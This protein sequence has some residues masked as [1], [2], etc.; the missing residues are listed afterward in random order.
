MRIK[1]IQIT[2]YLFV[3]LQLNGCG[4]LPKQ[5]GKWIHP[6]NS[7]AIIKKDHYECV[8]QAWKLHPEELGYISANN[9]YWEE[10][11]NARTECRYNE[12]SNITNCHHYPAKDKTWVESD[13][14]EGD[15][16]AS[17][18]AIKY[19]ECMKAK[20]VAYKCIKDNE[21]VNGSWCGQYKE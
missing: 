6:T 20:D 7:Q 18:R 8:N 2:F 9:G 1:Y 10:A 21:I 16:N 13:I 12:Y 11:T 19:T 5:Q 15:I 3:L 17:N 14:I 4:L